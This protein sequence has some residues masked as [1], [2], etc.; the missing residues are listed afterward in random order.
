MTRLRPVDLDALLEQL[1][2]D[3]GFFEADQFTDWPNCPTP[4][5][6]F[7]VCAWA[8]TGLCGACSTRLLGEPEFERRYQASRRPT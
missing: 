3:E 8:A 6:P 7:K 5:C 1:E 2:E 4:D